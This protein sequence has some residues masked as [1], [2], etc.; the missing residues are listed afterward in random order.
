M[1]HEGG[2]IFFEK[3]L[4]KIWW[5]REKVVTLHSQKGN[6]EALLRAASLP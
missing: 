2:K 5:F 4:R 6:N 3:F 1:V